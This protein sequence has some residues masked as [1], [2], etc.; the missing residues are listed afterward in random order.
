[1]SE[2]TRGLAK[3]ADELRQWMEALRLALGGESAGLWRLSD[4]RQTLS[5]ELATP[6]SAEDVPH[7]IPLSGH[8]LGWVVSE[9]VS[10]KASRKD[11]FRASDEGWLVAAPIADSK[12]ERIGC[13]VMEFGG[14]PRLDAPRSLELAATLAGRLIT[15]ARVA[16]GAL[17]EL[18]RYE[19]LYE[20]IRDLDRE[21]DLQGLASS[22]CRRALHV[23]GARGAAVASW[24]A[25]TSTGQIVAI[26]GALPAALANAPLAA[27]DSFLSLALQNATPLPRDDLTGRRNLSLYVAGI[28]S[29]AG[30]AIIVPMI[31]DAEPI[32]ALAV[33]YE[34]PRQYADGDVNRLKAL[35]QFVG[36]AF[37]NALEFGEVKALSL[38]DP[39][40]GLPNR[41]ASERALASAI[42][43]ADRTDSPFAVAVLDVDHFKRFNDIH[44]HDAGDL[45][46]RTVARVI[47]GSLRPG[48][49]C[50]RWGGEEFL[51]V[52]PSTRLE[53]AARG[54]ERI[55]QGVEAI[56]VA[57]SGRVLGVTVSGGVSAYP[58]V[59]GTGAATVPS[60]DA[61]LY[62]AKREGRNVVALANPSA[63]TQ[64][65]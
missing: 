38:T 35:A 11:I 22:V 17:S 34:K 5:L 2:W 28:E 6:E 54:I 60:A 37:R 50:G 58:E 32:G 44:G 8:A 49:H 20:A 31:V 46:L 64:G 19:L 21:L 59:V 52:L 4:D 47:A 7:A 16:E 13:V 65:I 36:L 62:R 14:V 25:A 61:A 42:A 57:W 1:M 30:S 39:L 27:G 10:L 45:V 15:D 24:E 33:E 43:V 26:D 55:R 41:R 40:T 48:D 29:V 53:D 51:V 63:Q 9:G 3:V 23:T 12:G 18:T 56:Q